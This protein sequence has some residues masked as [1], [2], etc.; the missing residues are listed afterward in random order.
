MRGDVRRRLLAVTAAT[1]LGG[2]LLAAPASATIGWDGGSLV[3][4]DGTLEERRPQ[5]AVDSSG[6]RHVVY[7]D[8]GGDVWLVEVAAGGGQGEPVRLSSADGEGRAGYPRIAVDDEDRITVAWYVVDPAQQ[9]HSHVAARTMSADGVLGELQVLSDLA[10]N[11]YYP[12]LV[13]DSTGEVTVVWENEIGGGHPGKIQAV[14]LAP[15]TGAPLAPVVDLDDPGGEVPEGIGVGDL[16]I[17]IDPADRA[18]V[19]WVRR[20]GDADGGFRNATIRAVRLDAEGVPGPI[21]AVSDDPAV[22]FRYPQVV[23]APDGTVTVVYTRFGDVAG[24]VATRLSAVDS[25]P[26]A[27]LLVSDPERDTWDDPAA[28]VDGKG[29]VTVAWL[30]QGPTD[31]T[32]ET[33]RIDADG[34]LERERPPVGVRGSTS[35]RMEMIGLASDA[36]GRV[37]VAWPGADGPRGG[38]TRMHAV[39]LAP[40]TGAASTTHRL[41]SPGEW[42]AFGEVVDVAMDSRHRA[43]VVWTRYGATA[44]RRSWAPRF[45]PTP[46]KTRLL[47][48]PR[49]GELVKDATPRFRFEADTV[50]AGFE[51][52]TDGGRWRPCTSPE[53]TRRLDKGRHTFAVRAADGD[54]TRPDQSP[55]VARFRVR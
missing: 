20:D 4:P 8:E 15:G 36:R 24:T 11:S 5:V 28:T 21:Q 9:G 25:T 53:T 33:R 54:G 13:A 29:R 26:G 12:E 19:A 23:V 50:E 16:T 47:S 38:E 1:A 41:S 27:P 49:N 10:D 37:V 35:A 22:D 6:D 52:R 2:T 40:G 51:C 46:A 45:G 34:R 44:V 31:F 7:D 17:G 18:T 3:V 14:R 42:D 43:S 30:A 32:V 48:G 39:R 55:E